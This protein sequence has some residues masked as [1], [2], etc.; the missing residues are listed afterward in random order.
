MAVHGCPGGY[1]CHHCLKEG[2]AMAVHLLTTTI[3]ATSCHAI[4]A[5]S[6][7]DRLELGFGE[8]MKGWMDGWMDN[9]NYRIVH[10]LSLI[11]I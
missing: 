5:M 8:W 2:F 10:M 9:W 7:S 4:G 11:H 6:V 3:E 1:I